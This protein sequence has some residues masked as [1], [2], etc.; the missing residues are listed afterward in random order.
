LALR[1]FSTFSQEMLL[2]EAGASRRASL[3]LWS[4]SCSFALPQYLTPNRLL[5]RLGKATGQFFKALSVLRDEE[6]AK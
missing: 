6:I 1:V 4:I 2:L 5:Q 3:A